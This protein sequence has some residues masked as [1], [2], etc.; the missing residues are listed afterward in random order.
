M[1]ALDIPEIPGTRDPD[2]SGHPKPSASRPLRQGSRRIVEGRATRRY[3]LR[4][5]VATESDIVQSYTVTRNCAASA[6][7]QVERELDAVDLQLLRTAAAAGEM[8]PKNIH[9]Q[10]RLDRL[11]LEGYVESAHHE[12][13]DGSGHAALTYRLT[14]KGRRAIERQ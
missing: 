8:S 5:A 4:L 2:T 14:P 11:D 12:L 7:G 13:A 1:L 9:Q 6:R 3:R 10:R